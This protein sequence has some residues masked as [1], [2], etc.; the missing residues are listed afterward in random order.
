[1]STPKSDAARA[2]GKLGG[3]AYVKNQ[4]PEGIAARVARAREA[5]AKKFKTPEEKKAYYRNLQKIS[6]ERK[7]AKRLTLDRS[8]A[9]LEK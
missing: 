9:N 7:R 1:M 6:T 5:L 2:L 8:N 3:I 4:S